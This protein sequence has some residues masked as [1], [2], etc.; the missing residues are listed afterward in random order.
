MLQV[1]GFFFPF[2]ED[3]FSEGRPNIIDR[4]TSLGSESIHLNIS[5]N[6]DR[7]TSLGSESIQ[8]YSSN[9]FDI[10]TSLGSES[11]HLNIWL[12]FVCLFF[13]H[14]FFFLQILDKCDKALQ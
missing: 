14:D 2:R 3:P 10:F 1:R 8:L 5:N 11:I 6:F 9:N 4:F 13:K 12:F 7:F